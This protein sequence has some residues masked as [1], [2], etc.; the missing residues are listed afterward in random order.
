[1]IPE[2][3]RLNKEKIWK[4]AVLKNQYWRLTTRCGW[5][6]GSRTCAK[7]HFPCGFFLAG[8]KVSTERPAEIDKTVKTSKH[9]DRALSACL[10]P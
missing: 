5:V 8:A 10:L 7:Q 4:V 6:S 2:I 3:R 9:F 1:M